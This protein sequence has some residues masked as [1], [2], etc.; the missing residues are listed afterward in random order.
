M[1]GSKRHFRRTP[2]PMR[3]PLVFLPALFAAL[4]ACNEFPALDDTMDREARNAPYPDL[5]PIETLNAQAPDPRIKPETAADTQSR[6]DRLKARA[7]RL[8]GNV[9]DAETHQRMQ[10]GV[11]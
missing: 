8:Q 11:E 6:I 5:V 2:R 1:K 10:D 4:S 9:I 7:A 3:L